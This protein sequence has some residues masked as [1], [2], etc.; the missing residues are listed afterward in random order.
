MKSMDKL[1]QRAGMRFKVKAFVGMYQCVAAIPSVFSVVAPPGLEQY[2]TWIH[3]IELPADLT[4][5]VIPVACVGSYR[6]RLL[7]GSCWPIVLLLTVT[8]SSIC[9]DLAMHCCRKGTTHVTASS[10]SALRNGLQR[11]LPL[12]SVLT[13]VLVPSTATAIFRTFLCE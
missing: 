7:L 3:L 2:T 9:W 8:T 12:A 11:I 6:T 4:N 13:F 5:L 1:W 10:R